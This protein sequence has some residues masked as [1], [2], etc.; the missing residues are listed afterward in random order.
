M[1]KQVLPLLDKFWNDFKETRHQA[2]EK[3]DFTGKLQEFIII[4]LGSFGSS[5][6]LALDAHNHN[7]LAID[8]DPNR[9]NRF[10][11]SLPNVI[12]LDATNIDG[13]HEIGAGSF[14]TGIVCIGEN[15]EASVLATVH[16]R[17]LGVRQVITKA[18]TPTQYEILNKVG[19]DLVILPEQESAIHLA[20]RLT[21]VNFVDFLELSNDTG[22]IELVAPARLIGQTLKEAD[23]RRKYGVV[24]IAIRRAEE[25][26]ISPRAEE[27]IQADDILV[28]LGRIEDC[29]R[30]SETRGT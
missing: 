8:S 3:F 26:L 19:A 11:N 16:L 25:V 24:V 10:A 22:V 28:V 2:I 15:F 13:L 12:E 7:V 23:V 21:S 5:L 30:L 27:C 6:A 4:G 29:D 17:K 18:D 14:D 1:T 9:V 20:R